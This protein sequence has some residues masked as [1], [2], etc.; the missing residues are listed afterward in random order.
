MAV[1]VAGVSGVGGTSV[2]G[3]VGAAGVTGVGSSDIVFSFSAIPYLGK[4]YE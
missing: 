2:T 1:G 4:Q 3:V